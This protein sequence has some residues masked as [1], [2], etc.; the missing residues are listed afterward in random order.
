MH[1]E[2]LNTPSVLPAH[3]GKT[4]TK[5]VSHINMCSGGNIVHTHIYCSAILSNLEVHS[6]SI[7]ST[8][9]AWEGDRVRSKHSFVLSLMVLPALSRV[10]MCVC[11]VCVHVCTHCTNMYSKHIVHILIWSALHQHCLMVHKGMLRR[12]VESCI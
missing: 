4:D 1:G 10:C 12:T 8:S 3:H 6:V 11:A 2:S 7:M 9:R 5:H